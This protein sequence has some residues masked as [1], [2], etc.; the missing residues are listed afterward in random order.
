MNF[1]KSKLINKRSSNSYFTSKELFMLRGVWGKWLDAV[2]ITWWQIVKDEILDQ[3]QSLDLLYEKE[4]T[5]QLMEFKIKYLSSY[6]GLL[7]QYFVNI[8]CSEVVNDI[9]NSRDERALIVILITWMIVNP[10]KFIPQSPTDIT[11]ELLVEAWNY[12]KTDEFEMIYRRISQIDT[13]PK[14]NFQQMKVIKTDYI[15]RFLIHDTLSQLTNS[16]RIM[17]SWLDAVL[18]FTVLKHEALILTVKKQNVIQK[19]KNVSLLWPK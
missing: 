12:M 5:N 14:L 16:A 3:V 6:A 9:V 4:T 15:D 17:A 1:L 8:N 10:D 11:P 19:I 7:Q 18:E 2:R 13:I